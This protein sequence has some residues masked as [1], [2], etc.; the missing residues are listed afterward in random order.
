MPRN[1]ISGTGWSRIDRTASWRW[2]ARR[3]RP[4]ARPK[5]E[6][7]AHATEGVHHGV[8][9]DKIA[10]PRRPPETRALPARAAADA[11][12]PPVLHLRQPARIEDTSTLR[13]A[14][15][16]WARGRGLPQELMVD[17]E[18][19]VYEAL[20]N[21]VE[22]AYPD[23]TTGTTTRPCASPPPSPTAAAGGPSPSPTRSAAEDWP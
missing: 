12:A 17:L 9:P 16:A 5:V 21:A 22:H 19:A 11:P 10:E 4:A 14:L 18:L 6:L 15:A 23:G 1:S 8:H 2:R 7:H 20:V 3:R 13:H